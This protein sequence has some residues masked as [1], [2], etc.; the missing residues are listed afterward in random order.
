MPLEVCMPFHIQEEKMRELGRIL[1]ADDEVGFAE[2]TADLLREEGYVCDCAADAF[3]ARRLLT[4][5]CYDLLVADIKMPGNEELEF[6]GILP[7]LAPICRSFLSPA[8][9]HW[10]PP[11]NRPACRWWGT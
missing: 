8:I 1:I 5:H 6:I 10:R 4:G 9:P 3:A 11:S 7:A 2:V